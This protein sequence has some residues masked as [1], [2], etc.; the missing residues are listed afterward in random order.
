M[1]NIRIENKDFVKDDG[2]FDID[3]SLSYSG[4]I[5]GICYDQEG[6]DHVL[7]EDEDKTQKRVNM[8]L[9][10][11]HHSVYGHTHVT[12]YIKG[13]SKL[14]AMI[15]NNEQEYNTSERSL[16]YT[17]ITNDEDS[18]ISD[19]EVRLYYKWLN[20]FKT[21]INEKY[22]DFFPARKVKTLAQENA[23]AL[24][25]VFMPTSMIY[26]T[27]LRQIN[28]IASWMIEY[29]KKDRKSVV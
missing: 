18:V 12:F 15:L 14:M 9:G 2:T 8:T 5:A 7:E 10:N 20:I 27:S 25:T 6:Y 21:K 28:Y 4:K 24:V 17:A 23:R 1:I 3:K 11:G 29:M 16:R 22:G 19:E 26:T 13:L